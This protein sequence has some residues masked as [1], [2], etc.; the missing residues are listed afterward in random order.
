M[1]STD[2]ILKT[3]P[4]S[5]TTIVLGGANNWKKHLGDLIIDKSDECHEYI[6]NGYFLKGDCTDKTFIKHIIFIVGKGRFKKIIADT[7]VTKMLYNMDTELFCL[8]GELLETGGI[9]CLMGAFFNRRNSNCFLDDEHEAKSIL[10]DLTMS[11]KFI[12]T[13]LGFFENEESKKRHSAKR[14][15]KEKIIEYNAKLMKKAGFDV[16]YIINFNKKDK[17]LYPLNIESAK[18]VFSDID[19]YLAT[20]QEMK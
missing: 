2:S 19:Y 18:F 14:Y 1:N 17:N 6:D 5:V 9:L 8:Y 13:A 7:N 12:N 15:G 20:R 11:G 16:K 10:S 3:L 4:K